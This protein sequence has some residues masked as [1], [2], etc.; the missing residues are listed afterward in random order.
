M[1]QTSPLWR[2]YKLLNFE[3]CNI[4]PR[5]GTSSES[6]STFFGKWPNP[7]IRI[8][9]RMLRFWD[10]TRHQGSIHCLGFWPF[11]LSPH[12]IPNPT[13]IFVAF[14]SSGW[15]KGARKT[16]CWWGKWKKRITGSFPF[17]WWSRWNHTD[18]ITRWSL[19]PSSFISETRH[20]SWDGL[21]RGRTW[22]LLFC[23]R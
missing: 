16:H 1:I 2:N 12:F 5:V 6:M 18:N 23:R 22:I 14:F 7:N 11:Y 3:V 20:K 4:V 10:T 8:Q 13:M 19:A 15:T 9:K 21:L 17:G